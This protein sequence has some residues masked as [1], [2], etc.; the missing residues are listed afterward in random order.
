MA[1]RDRPTL[2]AVLAAFLASLVALVGILIAGG[3]EEKDKQVLED[4][5]AFGLDAVAE[6]G[7]LDFCTHGPDPIG[8]DDEKPP[9]PREVAASVAVNRF[10]RQDRLCPGDGVSGQRVHVYVGSPADRPQVTA[11][12]IALVRQTLGLN[13]RILRDSHSTHAQKI[14][15]YCADGKTPTVTVAALP[16]VGTDGE[17]TFDD[18]YGIVSGQITGT[19]VLFLANADDAYPYCGEGT[20]GLDDAGADF[21]LIGCWPENDTYLHELGHNFGTVHP[22]APN[23]SGGWHCFDRADVMCYNDGGSYF[24]N[25][26]QMLRRCN[27]L[28]INAGNSTYGFPRFDCNND[29]YYS[30]HS[31]LTWRDTT[32]S[33]YLTK[34]RRK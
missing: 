12:Q 23:D 11:T 1:L 29:D 32:D 30:P 5:C 10:Y 18:W 24:Q 28:S 6:R 7:G 17:F 33:A 4:L 14:N 27:G 16:P 8:P 3:D 20:V 13:E 26:G 15:H 2:Q 31:P 25:G 9:L 34:S 19:H 21:S 22:E